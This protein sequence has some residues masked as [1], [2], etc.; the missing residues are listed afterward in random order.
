LTITLRPYQSDAAD[1]LLG[2]ERAM[3]LA[4]VGAGKTAITLTAMKDA[5]NKKTVS[6]F[7]VL[8]PKRV[9]TDVWPVE[10]LKWAPNLYMRVAVGT[11]ADRLSAL[12][13]HSDVVVTNYDNLQWLSEQELNFDAIVFDELTRL[14]NPSGARFKALNK[15]IDKMRVRWGLTGSFTSN[16]LEDVF[17][18]CKIVDQKLLGRSKG[19][20]MQQYF[21]L[22][23]KEFG[24]WAPRVG[25]LAKV[26]D[27]IRPATFVLEAG[28]YKDKLPP[29]HTVEIKCDMD[30]TPY[31]KLKK[32]FV[33]DDV[34][35]VNAAVVTG[36]LQQLASGFVY[37]TTSTPSESPG[38]FTVTQTPVWYSAHK[39]DRLEELLNEN[40]HANTI[41]AYTYQEELAELKRRFNVN[42]LDD[43]R[44]IERWNAGKVRL[45]AVHPKS[46][47]HGLNLQ[48]GGCHMVFLSL[49]WSLE[50]YEQ[51][52]GRLHRSGQQH[53][54][55]CYVMMTNKT[56]DEKIWAAL[57]DKRAIS[58]IAM[59]EL[60]T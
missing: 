38:K 3:I 27:V 35:A 39:F 26:M 37:D 20:F 17:G 13:S 21:V 2:H 22:I 8:A 7:L 59:E 50:L 60:R 42:T 43:D 54:V 51:T 12:R 19:A 10:V 47:G 5:L 4:P 15:V 46:A 24:E 9:A 44:A 49:P 30:L 31:N 1:F 18:Q 25:A 28:E 29:L 41:I 53:P 16:G 33:L 57:H 6:R 48:H 58:D 11:P 14:K 34:T 32:D 40:Q 23:N 45:L 36:K 52:I 55:W 56:V